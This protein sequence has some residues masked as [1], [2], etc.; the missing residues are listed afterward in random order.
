M[1]RASFGAHAYDL[2]ESPVAGYW[3]SFWIP[4]ADLDAWE[5]HAPWWEAGEVF[6]VRGLSGPDVNDYVS[7]VGAIRADDEAEVWRFVRA[8]FDRVPPKFQA[9]FCEERADPAWEPFTTRFPR[10]GWMHWPIQADAALALRVQPP[11]RP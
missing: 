8:C 11:A 9:R 5:C 4:R 1:P 10:T 7:I 2:G 6:H 3:Y